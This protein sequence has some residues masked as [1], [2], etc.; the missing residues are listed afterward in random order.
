MAW[1]QRANVVL[2]V[3]EDAVERMLSM[4]YEQID[5]RGNVLQQT[6]LL[7]SAKLTALYKEKCAEVEQLKSK[8]AELEAK[9]NS[10]KTK[11]K[12]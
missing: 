4:G 11:K 9:L 7:D 10:R 8:V 1:V 6:S 5:E 2:E 12:N 3:K